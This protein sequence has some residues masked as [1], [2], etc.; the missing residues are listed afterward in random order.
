MDKT[1][2]LI[3]LQNLRDKIT[4]L[5]D[6]KEWHTLSDW[7]DDNYK[8]VKTHLNEKFENGNYQYDVTNKAY[9]DIHTAF[10]EL[11]ESIDQMINLVKKDRA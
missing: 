3:I 1:A 4:E 11:V 7:F 9:N 5:T 2:R 10:D 6:E 8:K